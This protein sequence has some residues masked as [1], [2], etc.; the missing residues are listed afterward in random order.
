MKA[1]TLKFAM[2][3]LAVVLLTASAYAQG[4]GGVGDQGA[5]FGGPHRRQAAKKTTEP[6]KQKAD[7]KAYSA[8]LKALPDKKY[9]AW[10]GVR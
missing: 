3:A 1:G 9:N 8:A 4:V 2:A 6:P 5:G 10:N 7:E